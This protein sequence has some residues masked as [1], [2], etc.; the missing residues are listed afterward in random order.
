[1]IS[2]VCHGEEKARAR[3]G[4]LAMQF[5]GCFLVTCCSVLGESVETHTY[6]G[7]SMDS[8]RWDASSAECLPWLGLAMWT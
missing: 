6:F 2:T 3:K 8:P 4:V 1:M 7:P 5:G